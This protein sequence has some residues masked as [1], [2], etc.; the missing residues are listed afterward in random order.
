MQLL[1][2]FI[3]YY[4]LI[5]SS[6][7]DYEEFHSAGYKICPKVGKVVI[8]SNFMGEYNPKPSRH[9]MDR[10]CRGHASEDSEDLERELKRLGFEPLSGDGLQKLN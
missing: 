9:S 6:D 10:E 5:T 8:V 3:L 4:R 7:I 1:S 2:V